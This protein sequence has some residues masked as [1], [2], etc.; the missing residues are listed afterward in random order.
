MNAVRIKTSK[1]YEVVICDSFAGLNEEIA[2]ILGEGVAFIVYDKNTKKL[3][4]KE[5]SEELCDLPTIPLTVKAGEES[6]TFSEYKRLIGLLAKYGADRTDVLISVGGGA[7]SDL[8]G[9]VAATYKRGIKH[10]IVP[11]TILS[12]VDAAKPR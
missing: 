11:T 8:V 5:I 12:G 10:V 6:K 9:F 7:V 2:E 3:F 1:P 4:S